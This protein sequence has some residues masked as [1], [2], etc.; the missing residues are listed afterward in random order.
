MKLRVRLVSRLASLV[1]AVG[2]GG[3]IGV[4]S[5]LE[6]ATQGHGTHQQLGLDGCTVLTLTGWPCPMCGMTTTFSLMA[7]LRVVEALWTQPFGVV[8]FLLTLATLG[9]ALAELVWPTD[10]WR[11]L[12]RWLA[13]WETWAAGL[14]LAGLGLGWVWKIA[15]M[16]GWM[17]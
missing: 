14:F 3:V 5:W 16:R 4:A 10:R 11:R 6:P 15:L 1:V 7:D 2:A 13:P 12:W 9:V 17:G 8:L